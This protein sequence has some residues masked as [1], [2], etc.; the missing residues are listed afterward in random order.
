MVAEREDFGNVITVNHMII[1]IIVGNLATFLI[2]KVFQEG[3]VIIVL[4][5]IQDV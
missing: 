1:M 4:V 2:R 3:L 5:R